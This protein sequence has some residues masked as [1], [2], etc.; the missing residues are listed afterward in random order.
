MLHSFYRDEFLGL[1]S[2]DSGGRSQP[3]AAAAPDEL[4]SRMLARQAACSDGQQCVN[5]LSEAFATAASAG[6]AGCGLPDADIRHGLAK[7]AQWRAAQFRLAALSDKSVVRCWSPVLMV[8]VDWASVRRRRACLCPFLVPNGGG[9]VWRPACPEAAFL[10]LAQAC[11]IGVDLH[12][13]LADAANG[14]ATTPCHSFLMG[15]F[16]PLYRSGQWPPKKQLTREGRRLILNLKANLCPP[17]VVQF[18]FYSAYGHVICLRENQ[19]VPTREGLASLYT[20]ARHVISETRSDFRRLADVSGLLANIIVLLS[21]TVGQLQPVADR[22]LLAGLAGIFRLS[23][24]LF[25][26]TRD[27]LRQRLQAEATRQLTALDE[28]PVQCLHQHDRGGQWDWG[29]VNDCLVVEVCATLF[30]EMV[31]RETQQPHSPLDSCLQSY[32]ANLVDLHESDRCA[33]M[34]QACRDLR[35]SAGL[36]SLMMMENQLPDSCCPSP[37]FSRLFRMLNHVIQT[38][39]QLT[40]DQAV[41]NL[42]DAAIF[43]TKN[44]RPA[45]QSEEAVLAADFRFVT[46]F[47]DAAMSALGRCPSEDADL[48]GDILHSLWQDLSRPEVLA[49]L[50]YQ[51]ATEAA[52]AARQRLIAGASTTELSDVAFRSR[53]HRLRLL[54][55]AVAALL[56]GNQPSLD[57]NNN[58]E[59]GMELRLSTEGRRVLIGRGAGGL[60]GRLRRWNPAVL[61]DEL[62]NL[63]S[64][65]RL[66]RPLMQLL[67]ES[68]E[69]AQSPTARLLVDWVLSAARCLALLRRTSR[70]FA[71]PEAAQR[72]LLREGGCF[73]G[74]DRAAL[75]RRLAEE[76]LAGGELE[77]ERFSALAQLLA[78]QSSYLPDAD[79]EEKLSE[80]DF[81][82]DA[83]KKPSSNAPSWRASFLMRLL[84]Q[85]SAPVDAC[86]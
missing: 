8:P 57:F 9:L 38:L 45:D 12:L 65:P 52:E 59:H 42:A 10:L 47:T 43:L 3:T 7:F 68:D 17:E 53:Q 25:S 5:Q 48:D 54:T 49:M 73:E 86:S 62:L 36:L 33:A 4:R 24:P 11:G 28:S 37:E 64:K 23:P 27:R 72:G 31:L 20:V 34:L 84:P 32:L 21:H 70:R 35:C 61:S 50:K 80:F 46:A 19:R 14:T 76:L 60:V 6:C 69:A 40:C 82:E 71:S 63:L 16:V 85:P 18:V 75:I 56:L 58:D 79:E 81:D 77:L 41:L 13:R 44:R 51:E 39:L 67:A 74:G 22:H 26:E 15:D 78:L 1:R 2:G 30:R 66:G 83:S 29:D 55:Q